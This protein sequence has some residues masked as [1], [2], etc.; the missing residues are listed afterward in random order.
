LRGPIHLQGSKSSIISKNLLMWDWEFP[1]ALG[2]TSVGISASTGVS[3]L[4]GHYNASRGHLIEGNQLI[5]RHPWVGKI[6]IDTIPAAGDTIS[7][8]EFVY[9]WR[10]AAAVEGDIQIGADTT[11]CT[12]NL[13]TTIRGTDGRM[14]APNN[15]LRYVTDCFHNPFA[16][17]YG[18]TNGNV[19]VIAS[20]QPAFT[21]AKTGTHVTLTAPA[22]YRNACVTGIQAIGVMMPKIVNNHCD[23]FPTAIQATACWGAQ[24]LGNTLADH[25]YGI[26]KLF[27]CSANV[28]SHYDAGN[29]VLQQNPR[30]LL[31]TALYSSISD[32]F[33]VIDC[34]FVQTQQMQSKSYN[35]RSGIAT[36]G[37]GKA[38]TLLWYGQE[39]VGGTLSASRPFRWDDGD[40][41]L[42]YN[43]A[44]ITTFTFKRTAP[45]ALQF[46]SADSLVALINATAD[47]RAAY[48]DF[49]N[50][51]GGADPKLMIKI[52]AN[53]AGVAGNAYRLYTGRFK[54]PTDT[55]AIDT[56][57]QPL[58]VAQIL[59][60]P[61]AFG[62]LGNSFA[63]FYGGA[64]TLIKTF[65]P[66]PIANPDKPVFVQ[67]V[68]ATSQALAPAVYQADINSA[69]GFTITHL[70]GAGA[71]AEKFFWRV[72]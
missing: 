24:F 25:G 35:G 47:Y 57:P 22:D 52:W 66:T 27:D 9:T 48:V 34:P 11:E 7:L 40:V 62:T 55:S 56:I 46:N 17:G 4:S 15:V 30:P 49:Q 61:A 12:T 31:G 6:T 53:A 16:A 28:Y 20:W 18:E 72:G 8:G 39:I 63:R 14:T 32:G 44:A 5:H 67:G 59:R 60:D 36:V 42:L 70:A 71:G 51:L 1:Y 68:D 50:D 58:T 26:G 2:G 21:L 64:A 38:Y 23:D 54:T 10:A 13:V 65:V 29:R 41:V 69:V 33:S 19:A 37:D 45:G 43:G 3:A